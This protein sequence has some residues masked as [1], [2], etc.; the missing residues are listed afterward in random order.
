MSSSFSISLLFF[1]TAYFSLSKFLLYSSYTS[2]AYSVSI[3]LYF[4][5]LS[6]IS[7]ELCSN[8]S[9][10][11]SSDLLLSFPHKIA[12]AADTCGA[13]ILV[14]DDAVSN[15]KLVNVL[16]NSPGAYTSTS[17]FE[18]SSVTSALALTAPTDITSSY[19]AGYSTLA[20]DSPLFPAA[21]ISN[22]P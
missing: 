19:A 9:L 1:F 15:P 17:P 8:N 6:S 13:A 20:S 7:L 2:N 12:A 16:T 3:S 18:L 21:A 14:P 10:I 4:S 11:N 22:I 5:P